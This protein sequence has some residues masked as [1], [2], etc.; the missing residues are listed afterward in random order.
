MT[1][2]IGLIEGDCSPGVVQSLVQQLS[3][4]IN[5][6]ANNGGPR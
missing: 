2:S 3:P 6:E 4:T 1:Q 5:E